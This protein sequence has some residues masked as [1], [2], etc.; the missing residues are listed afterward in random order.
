MQRL[1]APW[2]AQYLSE[3]SKR[4]K[5][6]CLFCRMAKSDSDAKNYVVL[7]RKH[8]FV[9][10]NIYPYNNGHLLIVPY[11]HV[12][13]LNKMRQ[14]ERLEFFDLLMYT[15]QL[16]EEV[17][18]PEGFNIG[19]NIGHA[20]GAGVPKHLHMHIVPRWEGDVNFMPTVANIKVI[21][22]S[23][24]ELY[25]KLIEADKNKTKNENKRRD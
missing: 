9:V 18:H 14:D 21:S 10:L 16:L 19:M 25:R 23:L 24:D 6:G 3:M 7:R 4:E 2:R 5:G 11:R 12:S 15:K 1:W 20:A 13:D 17:L 8:C 22:Q